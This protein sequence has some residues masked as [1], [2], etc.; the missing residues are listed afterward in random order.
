M[1]LEEFAKIVILIGSFIGAVTT[2]CLFLKK[3]ILKAIQPVTNQ[4]SVL[5]KSSCMNYL[6]SFLADKERGI[7]KDPI[8]VQ[9]AYEIYDH[10]VKDLHGNSYIHDKWEKVMKGGR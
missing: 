2:I 9:R 3:V 5:D 7:E 10:Y 4:I 6:V 1:T 8:E